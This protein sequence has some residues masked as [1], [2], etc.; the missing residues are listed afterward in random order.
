MDN[1][2]TEVGTIK[3]DNMHTGGFQPQSSKIHI[4]CVLCDCEIVGDIPHGTPISGFTP[5]YVCDK[6]KA[7][8][9]KLSEVNA[10][11]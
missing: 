6:C 4:K 5:P 3:L 11:D 2:K 8:W 9:K 7:V 1:P 10:N